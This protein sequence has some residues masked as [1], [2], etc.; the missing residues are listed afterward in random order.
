LFSTFAPYDDEGYVLIS[1]KYFLQ[2]FRLYDQVFTQYG[3]LFYTYAWLVHGVL[4]VGLT[5]DAAR[6]LTLVH[7]IGIAGLYGWFVHR[8]SG[9]A[10]LTCAGF[11]LAFMHVEPLVNEPGHPL[12]ACGLLVGTALVLCSFGGRR[13]ILHAMALTG[14]MIGLLGMIKI[15]LA[16][17]LFL[18]V[19][20]AL[21]TSAEASRVIGVLRPLH[22]GLGLAV[23]PVLMHRWLTDEPTFVFWI[24][25]TLTVVS[26]LLVGRPDVADRISMESSI[27]RLVLAS[28]ATMLGVALA[29]LVQGVSIA[30]L[31]Q[32]V[33]GQH[34]KFGNAFYFFVDVPK[35]AGVAAVGSTLLAIVF[36]RRASFPPS[37]RR[38]VE[39]GL[40]GM[41]LLY[42]LTVIGATSAAFAG[43]AIGGSIDK[44][45]PRGIAQALM[46]Y[47][48][49]FSWL[50]LAKAEALAPPQRF[51]RLAL[52]LIASFQ[53][54][55]AFPI[56]GTQ[57]AFGTVLLLLTGLLCVH[58]VLTSGEPGA[59]MRIHTR[60][61][62]YG[63][64]VLALLTIALRRGE[65]SR[66]EYRSSFP[67]GLP[68]AARIRLPE[69]TAN[70][71]GRLV[72]N[73]RS[74]CDT[75]VSFPGMN[76]LYLWAR[77]EPPTA[78]NATFW[79]NMLDGVEQHAVARSIDAKPRACFVVDLRAQEIF[80]GVGY[81]PLATY[82]HQSFHSAGAMGPYD[83]RIRNDR[84][85]EELLP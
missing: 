48:L 8:A 34:V 22:V 54:L 81:S 3:P 32:G 77:M 74:Q 71:L 85:S 70:S 20:L 51:A 52:C 75:F 84:R 44:D 15:N 18:A 6:L 9:S 72:R 62:G 36:R 49:P 12:G 63:L 10:L 11:V 37:A 41:K 26:V 39:L 24:V 80:D 56:A 25:W 45:S 61:F 38:R 4:G 55:Q 78:Y 60:R 40:V 30:T 46:I 67:L 43:E 27:H 58:D 21:V 76:S 66:R 57:V 13:D 23:A 31:A 64:M 28:A 33:I 68:G 47:A 82:L 19:S 42:G 29:Q 5:H 1:I 35:K 73:L 83:L 50:L 59:P 7:W 65:I 2:G 16:V 53:T 79:P 69:E 14:L 17:F